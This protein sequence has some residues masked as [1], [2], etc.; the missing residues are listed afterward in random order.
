MGVCPAGRGGHR[1]AHH[2]PAGVTPQGPDD[3]LQAVPPELRRSAQGLVR[4]HRQHHRDH[5]REAEGRSE[6]LGEGARPLPRQRCGVDEE[7]HRLGQFQHTRGERPRPVAPHHPDPGGVRRHLPLDQPTGPGPDVGNHVDRSVAGQGLFDR[8]APHHL[9]RRRRVQG[10]ESRDQRGGRLLEVAASFPRDR[11]QDPQGRPARRPSRYRQD[12]ARPCRGRRGGR[13]VPVGQR[14]G[15]HGDVRRRRR[16][17]GPRP[18]PDRPQAGSRDHLRRRDRLHR[19]QARRR[20]RRRPRRAGADAQPD[21]VGDGRLR[22]GRG[23]RHHGGHQPP[24]HPRP[25]AV[26]PGPLRPSDRRPA[27]RP[28]GA[29]ADLGGP[30]QGQADRS[31]TST[32]SSWPGALPA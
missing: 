21:A 9:R 12:P 32:S 22:P 27:P 13:A 11:G 4:H 26:A 29:P 24:R 7:G 6:L 31:P 14:V 8:T 20:A 10:R 23:R 1:R 16:Q 25:R 2:P 3:P 18:L 30:L 5:H 19:S 15:L 17:P 28:R